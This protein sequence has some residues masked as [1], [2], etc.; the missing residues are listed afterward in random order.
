MSERQELNLES[1]IGK[2]LMQPQHYGIIDDA[3]CIG[4]GVDNTTQAYVVI[5]LKLDETHLLDI[6]F[7]S[8]AN[9]DVNTLGSLF[10]EMIKGDKIEEVLKNTLKLEQDLQQS[11]KDIPK[12]VVDTSKPEGEQVQHVSTQYQDSANMVLTAFRAA[13]RHYERKISG[14]EE[15]YF[16]MSIVK[17]CPYSGTDCHFIEKEK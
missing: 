7:G 14:I 9:H 12:P 5:Y 16:K 8:N 3:D 10:A 1:E 15:K 2:H 11:Y 6:K 13:M 4:Y 17:S